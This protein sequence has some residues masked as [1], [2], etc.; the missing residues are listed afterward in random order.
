MPGG[1]DQRIGAI[2]FAGV[3]VAGRELARFHLADGAFERGPGGIVRARVAVRRFVGIAGR[4][5]RRGEDRAG[6]QRLA[7]D[8]ASQGRANDFGRVMHRLGSNIL[9]ARWMAT[10]PE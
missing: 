1:E 9:T 7:G 6:M 8:R 4:V 10:R 2:A 3:G 5:V